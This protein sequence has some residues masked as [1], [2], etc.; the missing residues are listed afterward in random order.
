[1]IYI[2]KFLIPTGS[3]V[4]L[5]RIIAGTA[6]S[7]GLKTLQ[8]RIDIF[9]EPLPMVFLLANQL[10]QNKYKLSPKLNGVLSHI[11][12]GNAFAM[13]AFER[14]LGALNAQKIPVLAQKG[15]VAKIQNPQIIRPMSDADFAVPNKQY[16]RAIDAAI[17]AGF[18]LQF[19]MLGSADLQ[20]RD[21]GKIDIHHAMFK[22]ANPRMDE[23]IWKRAIPTK[24]QNHTIYI[25]TPEDHMVMIM[26][27]F[28]GNFLYECADPY[29]KPERQFGQ[30]PMWVLDARNIILRNPNLNWAQIINTAE[31]SE[32]GYQIRILAK[33]LNKI[34]PRL[35]SK[36][37][38]RIM[39]KICPDTY[40]LQKTIRDNKIVKLHQLNSKWFK[41]QLKSGKVPE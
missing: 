13:S 15:L 41:Q 1:M 7:G 18:T 22:G 34:F 19:N 28:Y 27:E 16:R 32:Y 29:R 36:P 33:L 10:G 25:P 17:D 39:K 9:S 38:L 35:I 12:F 37:N 11:R 20:Y 3:L 26:C 14:A 40:V 4:K 2:P 23:L 24:Y 31:L 21:M 6:P 30:H 5:Y 8:K